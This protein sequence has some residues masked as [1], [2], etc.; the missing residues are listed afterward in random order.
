MKTK[1]SCDILKKGMFVLTDG[2]SDGFMIETDEQ[3]D[4]LKRDFMGKELLIDLSKSW[5]SKNVVDT[6]SHRP[7]E[8]GCSMGF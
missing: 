5:I 2:S 8:K 3:L 1:V 4:V 6:L 7:S